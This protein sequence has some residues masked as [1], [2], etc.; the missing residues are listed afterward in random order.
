MQAEDEVSILRGAPGS[1][2]STL[3]AQLGGTT[4]SADNYFLNIEGDYIFN[5]RNLKAAH[6]SCFDRFTAA[7]DA[8]DKQVTVDNTNIHPR[9]YARY[10]ECAKQHGYRVRIRRFVPP[11]GMDIQEVARRLHERN[12]HEV[13]EHVIAAKLAELEDNPA[14]GEELIEIQF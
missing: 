4:C 2:K 3:A 5:W 8:R 13:P 1:G 11:A 6:K 14:D 9:H 12:V 10:I 7:L